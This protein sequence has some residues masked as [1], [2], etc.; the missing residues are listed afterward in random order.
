MKNSTKITNLQTYKSYQLIE[1][2]LTD[3]ELSAFHHRIP[4]TQK[5][6]NSLLDKMISH[7]SPDDEVIT[8]LLLDPQYDAFL[9]EYASKIEQ[10]TNFPAVTSE[11]PPYTMEES[12]KKWKKLENRIKSTELESKF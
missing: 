3:S 8:H 2:L 1:S 4:M 7:L 9:T 11:F 12:E 5:L 10:E 6:Y